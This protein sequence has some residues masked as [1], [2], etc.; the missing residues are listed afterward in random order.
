[1]IRNKANITKVKVFIYEL[2]YGNVRIWESYTVKCSYMNIRHLLI[3]EP[4]CSY[5]SRYMIIE[6]NYI[7]SIIYRLLM[8]RHMMIFFIIYE[9][10]NVHIWFQ[11]SHNFLSICWS[12]MV[13]HDEPYMNIHIQLIYD[14]SYMF[15]HIWLTI[16]HWPCMVDHIW[17][18]ERSYVI[19]D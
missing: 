16:Y 5:M 11:I 7:W 10:S 6:L 3:Y 12:Y 19:D 8:W 15:D 14:W 4:I 18:K 9:H 13:E 2:I 1:M 17:I